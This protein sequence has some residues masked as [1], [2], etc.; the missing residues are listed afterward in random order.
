MMLG[1]LAFLGYSN[2]DM[3]DSSVNLIRKVQVD[4]TAGIEM[5]NICRAVMMEYV[6]TGEIP[7]R[8]FSKFLAESTSEFGGKETRDHTC[9]MWGTPYAMGIRGMD[10]VVLSAGPDKTWRTEDD[11]QCSES[12]TKVEIPQRVQADIQRALYGKTAPP[13]KT[14]SN[15]PPRRRQQTRRPRPSAPGGWQMGRSRAAGGGR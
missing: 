3:L 9:D 2:I 13:A 11:I 12:L 6:N 4:V 1:A 5:R 15:S 7:L 14:G 10:I 8:N